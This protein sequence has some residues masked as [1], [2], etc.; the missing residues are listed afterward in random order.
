MSA[1]STQN[2]SKEV[3]QDFLENDMP[4][5]GQNYV[6]LSFVSPET[7]IADKKLWEFYQYT[8]AQNENAANVTFEAF[9]ENFDNYCLRNQESLQKNFSE[10]NDFA[11]SVRGI[12]VR[13]VYDNVVEAKYRAKQLQRSDPH[14]NVFVGQVGFWLP[15][16]PAPGDIPEQ[17]YLNSQLNTLMK[18]YR[19]NQANKDQL[20]AQHKDSVVKKASAPT[21][22]TAANDEEQK[23]ED[24]SAVEEK[25]SVMESEDPWMKKK[26][27]K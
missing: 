25:M 20:W 19:E 18:S 3:E 27:Q 5:P 14:F 26:M 7:C 4:I 22:V 2:E 17:E 13:G 12:K 11:T 15:W 16:D 23:F 24:S 10:Q 8:T 1:V 6:C 21:T 9:R